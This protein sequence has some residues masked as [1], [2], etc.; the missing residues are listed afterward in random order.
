MLE[1]GMLSA[2]LQVIM[3]DLVLAGDNAIVIGMAAAGL[4]GYDTTNWVGLFAPAGTSP[5]RVARLNRAVLDALG[6]PDVQTKLLELEAILIGSPPAVL[7]EQV[8]SE[9]AK[10]GPVVNAA[11]ARIE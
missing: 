11:G 2:F 4:P 9:L 6:D 1:S 5:E 8:R 10:W 7:A 3:I